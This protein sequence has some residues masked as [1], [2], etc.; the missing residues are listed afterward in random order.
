MWTLMFQF[1]R[2]GSTSEAYMAV[3]VIKFISNKMLGVCENKNMIITE[4][5]LINLVEFWFLPFF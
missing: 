3:G 4:M 1:E 2:T 5:S